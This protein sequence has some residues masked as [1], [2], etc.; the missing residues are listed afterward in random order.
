MKCPHQ[1]QDTNF[2]RLKY[3]TIKIKV[4]A[5]LYSQICWSNFIQSIIYFSNHNEEFSEMFL[6]PTRK[7][8]IEKQSKVQFEKSNSSKVNLIHS[9]PIENYRNLKN[10]SLPH[11]S[12]SLSLC[13]KPHKTAIVYETLS[14]D[15]DLFDFAFL[16]VASWVTFIIVDCTKIP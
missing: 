8:H 2:S 14:S 11:H 16:V 13:K 3:R 9:I 15:E 10:L 7:L 12:N 5:N 4:K 6:N 1:R